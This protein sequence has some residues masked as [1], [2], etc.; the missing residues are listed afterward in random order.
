[1]E[2]SFDI[3]KQMVWNAYR[4]IKANKG[5]AGI[6][7]QTMEDFDNDIKKNLYKI[8]N[9]L[10]SG[11][12]FPPAV[13]RVDI[14]KSNG[15]TRPLGI[16]TISDRIAQMVVKD[17]LEPTV[18]PYFHAD[19]YGYRPGKS[20]LDAVAQARQRCWRDDWVLDMDIR[21]FFDTIDHSLML[22]A[23]SK[24]T[25]CK[26]VLLYIKRW[27]VADVV[28]QNG[29]V[30]GRRMGTPQGGV[31]SPLL[32]NIFLHFVFDKWMEKGFP[33]VHFERYADDIVVHFRSYKQLKYVESKLRDRFS[34]CRLELCTE[35]TKVVY[36]KDSNRSGAFENQCFDF[37]GYTFSPRS[38]RRSDGKFFVSF[39]PA[40]SQKSLKAMRRRIKQHPAIQ[41]CYSESLEAVAHK[42]NPII[43]GWINYYG[44]FRKSSLS[45]IFYYINDKLTNWVMR[46]YKSLQRRKT[47]A[48]EWIKNLYLQ[49][50]GLFAHWKVFNWVAE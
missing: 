5:T 4:K 26:W 34:Q 25:Q 27:L 1:M 6:D 32:A 47:R 42:L 2:K 31:I 29:D 46:K 24:F 14:P 11:S 19:S 7:G 18:D 13:R 44:K 23:V 10:S 40:V 33:N 28:L 22:K 38:S 41:G 43:Q 17:Y 49:D 30:E 48:G 8:W 15:Q 20:A 45:A 37:L 12:Y 21:G 39:S 35:K 9:R 3:S 50:R 16:P 36:C